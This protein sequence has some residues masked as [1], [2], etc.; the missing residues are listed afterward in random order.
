M[1]TT[2]LS[3]KGQV[4]IPKPVRVAHKWKV[5]QELQV[6]DMEDGVLLRP[7]SPFP[8]SDIGEVAS[9]LE[10]SGRAKSLE[11]MEAAIKKGVSESENAGR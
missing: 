6:I 11:E 8:A 3:T 4:I 5:G 10:Y 7:K 9:C 2:R 1:E